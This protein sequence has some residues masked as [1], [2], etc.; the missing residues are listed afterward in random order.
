MS[1]VSQDKFQLVGI[2]VYENPVVKGHLARPALIEGVKTADGAFWPDVKPQVANEL[3]GKW[4]SI[5]QASKGGSKTK[6]KID[7]GG[8][9]E[10]LLV[11]LDVFKPMIGKYRFG[12]LI[13][14]TGETA[15]FQLDLLSPP[16]REGESK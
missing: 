10:T 4:E 16:K 1:F 6:L 5:R 13:L 2:C 7:P 14:R 15:V 9:N 3:S 11:A 12:K 8:R